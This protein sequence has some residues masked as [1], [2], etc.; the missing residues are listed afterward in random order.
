MSSRPDLHSLLWPHSSYAVRD[1]IWRIKTNAFYVFRV[2]TEVFPLLCTS[3]HIKSSLLCC[4]E[5]CERIC[6]L[7]GFCV[8]RFLSLQKTTLPSVWMKTAFVNSLKVQVRKVESSRGRL[9]RQLALLIIWTRARKLVSYSLQCQNLSKAASLPYQWS[10]QKMLTGT[11]HCEKWQGNTRCKFSPIQYA[12]WESLS[13]KQM[14]VTRL[15]AQRSTAPRGDPQMF[16]CQPRGQGMRQHCQEDI[17]ITPNCWQQMA[18][19]GKC[20]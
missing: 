17:E 16:H 6:H 20:F 5:I 7:S 2:S 8:L 4:L 11:G 15:W 1:C 3:V 18:A 10:A 13:S 12:V 19:N 9:I 14:S